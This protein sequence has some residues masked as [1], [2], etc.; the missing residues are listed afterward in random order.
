[1]AKKERIPIQ[2][3]DG[4]ESI[5]LEL[6]EALGRLDGANERIVNLLQSIETANAA[7]ETKVYAEEGDDDEEH[8]EPAANEPPESSDE[9]ARTP[10]E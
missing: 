7:D 8:V 6:D 4:L 9:N 2:R 3:S 5:D 10:A 1:M